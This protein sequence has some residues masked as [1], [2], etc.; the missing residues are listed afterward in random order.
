MQLCIAIQKS[1]TKPITLARGAD[2][3]FEL[4]C[5]QHGLNPDGGFDFKVFCFCNSLVLLARLTFERH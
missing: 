4:W 5:I 1:A 3:A 2:A